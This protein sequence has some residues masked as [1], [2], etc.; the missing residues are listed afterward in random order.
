MLYFGKMNN[1]KCRNL[2]LFPTAVAI[3]DHQPVDEQIVDEKE[4]QPHR[5]RRPQQPRCAL[6]KLLHHGGE[7]KDK[8]DERVHDAHAHGAE[9]ELRQKPQRFGRDRVKI[10]LHEGIIAEKAKNEGRFLI[11]AEK[12]SQ[13]RRRG[14]AAPCVAFAAFL[15]RGQKRSRCEDWPGVGRE[16]D[17]AAEPEEGDRERAQYAAERQFMCFLC[18][19]SNHI[20]FTDIPAPSRRG[21]RW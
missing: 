6:G 2:C 3:D 9:T 13:D 1:K 5:R 4:Q 17:D 7:L 14:K 21:A 11:R 8:D 15:A 20:A 19:S 10:R 12:K 16:R 18:Q